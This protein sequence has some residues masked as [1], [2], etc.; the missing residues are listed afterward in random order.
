MKALDSGVHFILANHVGPIL[1]A[2][3]KERG[4]KRS[5]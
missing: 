3:K 2:K 4:E 5:R 1:R